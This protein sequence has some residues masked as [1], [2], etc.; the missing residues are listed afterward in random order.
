M[1]GI[2]LTIW[3]PILGTWALVVGT[4]AFAYWQLRQNQ[5]LHST[6]TLLDLRERFFGLRMRQAR[7]SLS[8]WL[9][10]DLRGE[11]PDNWEVAVFFELLASLTRSRTLD[12]RL[13]RNAFGTWITGYYSM[14][15]QPVDLFAQWRKEANDPLIF[16]DFEWLAREM[17]EMERRRA[18]G[19]GFDQS[20]LEEARYVMEGE[21]RL[22]V[23]A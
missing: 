10:A 20:L 8:T 9:R 15:R 23:S 14:I 1:A 18:P 19:P 4:L 13:V 17:I 3:V 11:E 21:S 16:A 2:D 12:K 7:R 5:R 22:D 6:S